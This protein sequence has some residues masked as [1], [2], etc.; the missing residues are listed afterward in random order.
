MPTPCYYKVLEWDT[1]KGFLLDEYIFSYAT[2]F[3]EIWKYLFVISHLSTIL[4]VVME[5]IK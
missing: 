3:F 1:V 2:E 4:N 5:E